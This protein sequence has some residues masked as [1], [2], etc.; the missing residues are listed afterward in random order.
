M[1]AA[2]I[3]GEAP[4]VVRLQRELVKAIPRFPND[5]ASLRHMQRKPFSEVMIDYLNW[6]SR[7]VGVRPRAVTIER[8]ADNE[9]HWTTARPALLAFLEKVEE[10]QDLTP[11]LSLAPHTKGYTPAA[12]GQNATAD[13]RWSDK[14]FLLNVMGYHHFHLG[15]TTAAAGQVNRTDL[16]VFARVTRDA[17]VLIAIFDH[18]VFETCSAERIRLWTLHDKMT[19]QGASPGSV[20]LSGMI[21]MSGHSL[22]VVQSALDY[23]RQI[24]T[25]DANLGDTVFVRK[26]FQ[27][28]DLSIPLKPKFEWGLRHLDLLLVEHSSQTR[29][30]IRRGW[31]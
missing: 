24:R 29:F 6:R 26:L 22:T 20:V 18:S 25:V 10:G 13:E 3:A 5:R 15:T 4:R 28:A 21:T 2:A 14:D 16:I 9:P 1:T 31:S 17:F 30:L 12:R 27:D 23:V 19:S 11:H 7:Y 8:S